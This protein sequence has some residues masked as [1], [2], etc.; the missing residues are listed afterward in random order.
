MQSNDRPQGTPGDSVDD[1]YECGY[2]KPPKHT[3]FR[4]GQSGNPIGRRKGGRNLMTDVKR[5]LRV[6][7]KVK[8]SGRARK[9]FRFWL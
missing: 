8:E 6:P 9:R 4:A 1:G 2:G 5:T 7:V 3:R